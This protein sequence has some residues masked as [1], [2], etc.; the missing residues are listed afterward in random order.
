MPPRVMVPSVQPAVWTMSVGVLGIPA[1]RDGG[2]PVG[3]ELPVG[4]EPSGAT[5]L[6]AV[7]EAVGVAPLGGT[8]TEL[9]W[10]TVG[11]EQPVSSPRTRSVAVAVREKV[12]MMHLRE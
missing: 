6:L 4:S 9:P 2:A 1:G 5:G 12:I 8:G 7:L 11:P 3:T 10:V